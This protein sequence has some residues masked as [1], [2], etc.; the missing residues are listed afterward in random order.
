MTRAASVCAIASPS[1]LRRCATTDVLGTCGASELPRS[2]HPSHGRLR[3][4]ARCSPSRSLALAVAG[5]HPGE[6]GWGRRPGHLPTTP[7]GGDGTPH[8]RRR[9][10]PADNTSR[11]RAHRDLRQVRR[12]RTRHPRLPISKKEAATLG[13]NCPQGHASCG[14][15]SGQE[16]VSRTL[17]AGTDARQ[18]TVSAQDAATQPFVNA[19]T[20]ALHRASCSL[21]ANRRQ[22]LGRGPVAELAVDVGAPAIGG[23]RGREPAGV[24]VTGAHRGEAHPAR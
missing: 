17:E 1:S 24:G 8:Q 21:H 19:R 9:P 14:S 22:L 23:A 3:G 16:R 7:T 5:A 13:G 10:T 20:A 15:L 12:V 11:M 6:G 4:S 18:V 2:R